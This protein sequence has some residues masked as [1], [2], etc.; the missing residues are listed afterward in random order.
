MEGQKGGGR[1]RGTE[2]GSDATSLPMSSTMLGEVRRE[3]RERREREEREG[4]RS[5][6]GP[7][8]GRK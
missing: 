6:E 4:E 1:D 2:G 7:R 3:R 5:L 8:G